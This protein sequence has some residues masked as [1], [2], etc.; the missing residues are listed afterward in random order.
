M[1]GS[2]SFQEVANISAGSKMPRSDWSLVSDY[3]LFLPPTL[4]EQQ[5][6][7]Q[8]FSR[9]DSLIS[10]QQKEIDKLKTIKKSLLQKMFV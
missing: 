9:Y 7:G 10:L 4:A 8:F 1:I 3:N 2:N 5:K 6:I